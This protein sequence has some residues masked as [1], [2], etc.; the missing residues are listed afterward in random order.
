V[1]DRYQGVWR[2]RNGEKCEPLLVREA[3]SRKVLAVTLLAR[4][5]AQQVRRILLELF[6]QHGHSPQP[7]WL[8]SGSA[9]RRTPA[10]EVVTGGKMDRE[11]VL[12][13]S[14]VGELL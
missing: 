9:E 11:R 5:G 14:T 10:A 6:E 12:T 1:D 7:A 2:A 3:F 4:S 13:L 8:D